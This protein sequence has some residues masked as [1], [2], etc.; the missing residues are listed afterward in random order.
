MKPEKIIR[1][2]AREDC[3]NTFKIKENQ[4]NKKYC[5]PECAKIVRKEQRH[6]FK[7]NKIAGIY[8]RLSSENKATDAAKI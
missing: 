6:K 5:C 1:T 3:G 4:R 2:C 7:E 8:G